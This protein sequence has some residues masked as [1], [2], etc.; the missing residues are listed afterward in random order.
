MNLSPNFTLAELTR[1]QEATRR[2]ISNKPDQGSIENLRDLC[3]EVLEPIRAAL[4]PVY[5]SSGYRCLKLNR[6]LGSKDDSQHVTGNAA[7]IEVAVKTLREVVDWI[8][9]HTAY[10][11]VILEFPPNGWVHVSYDP[12]RSRKSRLLAKHENGKTVYRPLV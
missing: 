10:D 8:H 7:D 4:G 2:G 3:R 12:A 6:S 9:A 11:Q 1:S 5:I